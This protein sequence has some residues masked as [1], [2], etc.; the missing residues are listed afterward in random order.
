MNINEGS[1]PTQIL[2]T[3]KHITEKRNIELIL[4]INETFL[5]MN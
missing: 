5:S 2:Y 1:N 4:L 3:R